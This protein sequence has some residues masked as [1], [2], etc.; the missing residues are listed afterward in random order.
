MFLELELLFYREE[1]DFI[2]PRL[3]DIPENFS[4]NVSNWNYDGKLE[5]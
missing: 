5:R 2:L 4:V 3:T 1:F